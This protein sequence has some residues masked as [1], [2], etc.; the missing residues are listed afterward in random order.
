M[1]ER[2]DF[3]QRMAAGEPLLGVVLRST[4]PALAE[5]VGLAGFDFGWIDL[6]HSPLALRDV[7]AA[8]T[9][10]ELRGCV[11]LVRVPSQDPNLIGQVLDMGARIVDVPHVESREQALAIVR[12]ARFAPKGLRGFSSTT[13]A[14]RFGGETGSP[15]NLER[16]NRSTLVMVQIESRM[17]MERL[18]GI[19]DLAGIDILFLG[20]GDLGQDLGVPG[21]RSHPLIQEACRRFVECALRA[22]KRA[23]LPIGTPAELRERRKQGFSVFTCGVDLALLRTT[24]EALQ[25]SFRPEMGR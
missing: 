16:Q 3:A 18:E 5:L 1:E 24:L 21:Q 8:V 7:Q 11:P 25:A 14:N 9:A 6:E 12:A 2:R 23:A 22:G 19:A 10:L 20:T 15:E 13:R 4:D 17:G